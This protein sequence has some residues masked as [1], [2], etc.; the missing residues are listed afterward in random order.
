MPILPLLL[1]PI[2]RWITIAVFIT[3]IC[4]GAYLKIQ[5]DAAEKVITR[6]QIQELKRLQNALDADERTRR[7]LADPDG[8][9]AN[10]GFRRD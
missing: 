8:L 4:L 10:D 6:Q 9:R 2:G 7:M 5:K 3:A 1:S